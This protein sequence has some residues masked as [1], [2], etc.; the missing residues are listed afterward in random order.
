MPKGVGYPVPMSKMVGEASERVDNKLSNHT[1]T[2]KITAIREDYTDK[3]KVRVEVEYS[4]GDSG[5]NSEVP[6]LTDTVTISKKQS[7]ELHLGE[8]IK[9]T[10]TI[11]KVG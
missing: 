2:G 3:Q 1:Q 10:T 9:V 6:T 7:K 4:N 5:G 11:E 8:R